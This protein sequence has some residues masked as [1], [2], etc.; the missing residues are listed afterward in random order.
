MFVGIS[1]K[2]I[3]FSSIGAIKGDLWSFSCGVRKGSLKLWPHYLH[4]RRAW[5]FRDTEG[6]LKLKQ[7]SWK[8]EQTDGEILHPW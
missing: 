6:I 3:F 8:S 7:I 4:E 5:S 2:M 1:T